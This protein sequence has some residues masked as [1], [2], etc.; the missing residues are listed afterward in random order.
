[1]EGENRV[2][3]EEPRNKKRVVDAE[4]K[5]WE[6]YQILTTLDPNNLTR[7]NLLSLA[8]LPDNY[9]LR[10]W[11][12]FPDAQEVIALFNGDDYASSTGDITFTWSI[13]QAHLAEAQYPPLVRQIILQACGMM[14]FRQ[15]LET[16]GERTRVVTVSGYKFSKEEYERLINDYRK[17]YNLVKAIL[18]K[19]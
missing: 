16:M 3:D 17:R 1:M 14:F 10:P 9:S 12:E 5:L 6:A 19:E 18:E 15:G 7:N 8:G 2:R 13:L 4:K 11:P